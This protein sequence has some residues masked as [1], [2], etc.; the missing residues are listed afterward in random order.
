MKMLLGSLMSKSATQL[1]AAAIKSALGKSGVNQIDEV[2]MGCVL[3][4]GL[5]QAPARQA[6]MFA[7]LDHSTPCTTVNKVCA[8]GMKAMMLSATTLAQGIQVHTVGE[9]QTCLLQGDPYASDTFAAF[10]E[11]SV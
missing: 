2:M 7:G 10:L 4:A 6:A 1:G 9:I 3:Q 8:S 11:Q 5:G